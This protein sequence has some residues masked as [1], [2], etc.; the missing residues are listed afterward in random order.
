MKKSMHLGFHEYFEHVSSL[1]DLTIIR[2]SLDMRYANETYWKQ[3]S[4]EAIL[5]EF[6]GHQGYLHNIDLLLQE[7]RYIPLEVDNADLHILYALSDNASVNIYDC[8]TCAV[9]DLPSQRAVYLYLPP[10][11]YQFHLPKGITQIFGFYF[12]A[13]IFRN[14]NER[15]YGFIHPL[16]ESHRAQSGLPMASRNFKVGPRTR[17]H[18][19][20]LCKNLHPEQLNNDNFVL[21]K[22][23]E[24]IELSRIKIGQE[25][26]KTHHELRI[27]E[28]AQALLTLYVA[29]EGQSANLK[30]L[31]DDLGY[32][33]ASMNR[34]HKTYFG[35]TLRTL[36][37]ELLIER[38][39]ALL[40]SG[41][42]PTE[43][44]YALNY[45]SPE[46]FYHFFKKRT[47][48]TPS[49]FLD[50]YRQRPIP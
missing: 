30:K 17:H 13:S 4:E 15:P 27:A 18:I 46:A 49:Q 7:E 35:K 1:S 10:G 16:L 24:L 5:Q 28:E 31:E 22:L 44:A 34:F 43:C 48:I 26:T 19:E 47:G 11:D 41:M 25:E 33:L 21:G 29:Q 32:T 37:E 12:R 36:R 2:R 20:T 50:K 23:I 9:C 8:Q 40:H 3:Q 38:A 45:N 6:D 42:S 39:G 14:G